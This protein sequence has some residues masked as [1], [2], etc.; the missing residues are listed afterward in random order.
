MRIFSHGGQRLTARPP[1]RLL[2]VAS[3]AGDL[4]W[5]TILLER[6]SFALLRTSLGSLL[7]VTDASGT[8]TTQQRYLPFGEVRADVGSITQTDFGY[9]EASP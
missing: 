6:P 5:I 8:L 2:P 7:A 4:K 1:R 9:R 3:C